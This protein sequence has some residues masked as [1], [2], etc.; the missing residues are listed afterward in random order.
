V[1]HA[2]HILTP[3]D[4]FAVMIFGEAQLKLLIPHFLHC[5]VTLSLSQIQV[6]ST[7]SCSETPSVSG[8]RF[9]HV[10]KFHTNTK[11]ERRII[12]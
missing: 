8:R 7:E 6:F 9:V 3:H 12:I 5:A 10:K 1:L 2:Q 11:Q 4:M